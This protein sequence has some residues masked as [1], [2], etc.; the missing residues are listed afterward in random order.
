MLDVKKTEDGGAIVGDC[1]V[2][3]GSDHF[4]HSSRT[5]M[6]GYVPRVD[7]TMSTT[8]SMALMFEM[9]CPIPSMESVPSRRRRMVG[10]WVRREV[11]QK[12]AHD[13]LKRFKL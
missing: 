8:A 2:F 9:I 6:D 1:S 4:I 7:L 5:Y 13:Y 12:V 10:C 3:V 11:Y